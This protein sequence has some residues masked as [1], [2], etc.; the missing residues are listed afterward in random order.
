MTFVFDENLSPRHASRL[1]DLGF[2]AVAI[3]EV[4]LS[5]AADPA[6][7]AFAIDTGRVLITM[8][9]DFANVVRYPAVDRLLAKLGAEN[10]SGKLVVADQDKI[11]VRG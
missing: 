4:G 6:V 10:L 3:A 9:A 5:G 2:D 8:D 1:R 11:R 7:R